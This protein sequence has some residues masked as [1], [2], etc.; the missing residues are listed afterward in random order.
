MFLYNI[1]SI[2]IYFFISLMIF[3]KNNMIGCTLSLATIL[4]LSTIILI[5][6]RV[7]FLSYIFILVYVGGIAILFLFIIIMLNIKVS[8][9][10]K[11]NSIASSLLS[12]FI[13]LSFILLKVQSFLYNII[14]ESFFNSSYYWQEIGCITNVPVNDSAS[15]IL[16][17]D[18]LL[19]GTVL[20]S[21]YFFY[22]I[23]LGVILLVVMVAVLVLSLS[24]DN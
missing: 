15:K 21:T 1:L 20:Y 10:D 22:F 14:K 8:K 4:F 3:T 2:T 19:I 24:E 9:S 16:S 6:S 23:L 13:L 17:N 11:T 12:G 5:T 7:E 18:I